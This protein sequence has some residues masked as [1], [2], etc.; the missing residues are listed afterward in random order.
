MPAETLQHSNRIDNDALAVAAQRSRHYIQGIAD[1]RVAPGQS[2]LAA[3]SQFHEPFPE[4]S[5]DPSE[6][7]AMLDEIGSPATVASTGNRYFGFVIGG[8]V[9][10]AMAASWLASV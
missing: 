2:D 1:R 9:P 8:T 4:S 7:I 5:T 10:A 6:V 3:L